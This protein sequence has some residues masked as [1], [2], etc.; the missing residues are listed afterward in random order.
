[1]VTP[2]TPTRSAIT[3][4]ASMI[5]WRDT[6]LPPLGPVA[7][8]ASPFGSGVTPRLDTSGTV[9]DSDLAGPLTGISNTVKDLRVVHFERGTRA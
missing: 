9:G 1:M 7:A 5:S 4:A 3:S 6:S 2:A 8:A